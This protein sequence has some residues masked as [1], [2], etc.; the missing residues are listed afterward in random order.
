M[1]FT[2]KDLTIHLWSVLS[3][4][5]HVT[6]SII[7]SSSVVFSLW[8]LFVTTYSPFRIQTASRIKFIQALPV[9]PTDYLWCHLLS[10]LFF[11]VASFVALLHCLHYFCIVFIFSALFIIHTYILLIRTITNSLVHE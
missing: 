7:P 2:T 4:T 8:F 11:D 1:P 10:D 6:T 9:S 5:L 3:S